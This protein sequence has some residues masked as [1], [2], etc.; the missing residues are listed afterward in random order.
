MKKTWIKVKRGILEPKH[1]E[2]LGQAWYLYFY[3]LDQADWETGTIP[4]WKDKFAADELGK[5]ISIIREHRKLLIKNGYIQAI[6][7]QYSLTIIINNWTNP[8]MYDG[9]VINQ[10][11][12]KPELQS[13]PQ[14]IEKPELQ[15][16][17][18]PSKNNLLPYNHILINT[19]HITGEKKSP[20]LEYEDCDIDGEPVKVKPTKRHKPYQFNKNNDLYKIANALAEVSGMSLA[21]NR[22]RLFREAKMLTRDKRVTPEII[23]SDYLPGGAWY[24]YDWRGKRGQKPILTQVRETLFTFPKEE[25]SA[26]EFI[27]AEFLANGN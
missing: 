15:S 8:R 23:L 11:S 17:K 4:E 22:E 9:V 14:S 3:I 12:E 27:A 13:I 2:A 1:I 24:K 20:E 26:K 6:K 16:V 21:A 5:Q 18:T 25:E 19:Y 10:N 7:N